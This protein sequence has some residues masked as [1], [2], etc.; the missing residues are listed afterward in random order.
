MGRVGRPA[1]FM[2][3]RLGRTRYNPMT[4]T[5]Y[6]EEAP[7]GM[8]TREEA[9]VWAEAQTEGVIEPTPETWFEYTVTEGEAPPD[10]EPRPV[11]PAEEPS[12]TP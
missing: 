6:A 7:D 10:P 3:G 4:A 8:V 12:P 11:E 5:P 9:E 2:G 1:F